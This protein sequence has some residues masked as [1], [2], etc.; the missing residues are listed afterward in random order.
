MGSSEEQSKIDADRIEF[1]IQ[2]TVWIAKWNGRKAR[3]SS[4]D[5][6][7]KTPNWIHEGGDQV[8][9]RVIKGKEYL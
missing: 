7:S 1:A 3:I 4:T 6:T 5:P 8:S 9:W 2:E